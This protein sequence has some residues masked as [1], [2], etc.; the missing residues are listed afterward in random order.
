M[1]LLT[2]AEVAQQLQISVKQLRALVRAGKIRY[3]NTGLGLSRETRRFHPD[4]IAAFVRS[5]STFVYPQPMRSGRS[6]PI[7]NPK[8]PESDFM[9]RLDEAIKAGSRRR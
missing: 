9:R 1:Q 2:P 7:P 6:R 3:V 8:T 4:D 5:A